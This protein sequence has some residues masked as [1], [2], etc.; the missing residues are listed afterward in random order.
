MKENEHS[1]II[2]FEYIRVHEQQQYE[3]SVYWA[4]LM[5]FTLD[6]MH[7]LRANDKDISLYE[8]CTATL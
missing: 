5:N 3:R 6:Y 8:N 4:Y 7:L 2:Y 1:F